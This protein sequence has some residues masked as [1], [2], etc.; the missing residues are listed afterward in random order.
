M[1]SAFRG[2]ALKAGF[3]TGGKGGACGAGV[4]VRAVEHRDRGVD[5]RER[6]LALLYDRAGESGLLALL[7]DG[8]LEARLLPEVVE[9]LHAKGLRLTWAD[10]ERVLA[11]FPVIDR[12]QRVLQ[13]LVAGSE[14]P[15]RSALLRLFLAAYRDYDQHWEMRTE[16]YR[17]LKRALDD[18][19][20]PLNESERAIYQPLDDHIHAVAVSAR[21]DP[22]FYDDVDPDLLPPDFPQT[23][24]SS[25]DPLSFPW[26]CEE[27]RE[28]LALLG[29]LKV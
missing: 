1:H 25:L 14:G 23:P 21:A 9:T 26:F 28:I 3:P 16:I 6:E 8:A 29:P 24:D 13:L 15:A 4:D 22:Y 20:E 27:E 11:R 10:V 2:G 5:E 7:H 19:R 12:R 18:N 17:R